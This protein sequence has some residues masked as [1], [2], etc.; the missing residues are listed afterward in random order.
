MLLSIEP[1][2]VIC[3]CKERFAERNDVFDAFISLTFDT[4]LFSKLLWF[5][6]RT[7]DVLDLRLSAP[8]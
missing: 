2:K 5:D 8:M 1:A 4:A 7:G 6:V 3:I